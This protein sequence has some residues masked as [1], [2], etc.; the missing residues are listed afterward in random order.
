MATPVLTQTVSSQMFEVKE[1]RRDLIAELRTTH[2]L[3][4]PEQQQKRTEAED[5][6]SQQQQ[7]RASQ[8]QVRR[9]AVV[10]SGLIVNPLTS[11]SHCSGFKV[12]LTFHGIQVFGL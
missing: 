7:A 5:I 8:H 10:C 1:N 9:P 4:S 3:Q 6:R 2:A 12:K 11:V